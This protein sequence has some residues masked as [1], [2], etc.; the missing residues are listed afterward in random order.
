MFPSNF[1]KEL[2]SMDDGETQDALDDT[3]SVLFFAN[4]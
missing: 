4:S 1:V 3:G 2:E